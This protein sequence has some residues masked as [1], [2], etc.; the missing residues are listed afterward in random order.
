MSELNGAALRPL[1]ASKK[2]SSEVSFKEVAKLLNARDAAAGFTRAAE[3]L[4]ERFSEL[5]P[6]MGAAA[7]IKLAIDAHK[8][9]LFCEVAADKTRSQHDAAAYDM[10]QKY[11]AGDT[12]VPV[13]AGIHGRNLNSP[14]GV[15]VE[16]SHDQDAQDPEFDR[17]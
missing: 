7:T 12:D 13:A 6:Q 16:D 9:A 2:T 3:I 11:L 5:A 17:Q 4:L 15:D 14:V 1:R 10:Y 8:H